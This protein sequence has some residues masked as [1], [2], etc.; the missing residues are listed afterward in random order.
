MLDSNPVTLTNLFHYRHFLGRFLTFS[1]HS[2]KTLFL[3]Y[4]FVE[5]GASESSLSRQ[6]KEHFWKHIMVIFEIL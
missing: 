5:F 2:Q 6:K 4:V 1:E 3:E